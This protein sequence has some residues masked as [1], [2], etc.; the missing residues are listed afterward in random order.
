MTGPIRVAVDARLFSGTSGGVETVVV[1]LADGLSNVP[2]P[3]VD[4]TFVAYA[5]HTDWIVNHIGSSI[6][7]DRGADHLADQWRGSATCSDPCENPC[8]ESAM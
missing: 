8:D 7:L 5:G 4:I 6:H 2:H 3:D 1:G